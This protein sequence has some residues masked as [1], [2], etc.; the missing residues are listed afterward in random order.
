MR[1]ISRQVLGT[2]RE[3]NALHGLSWRSLQIIINSLKTNLWGIGLPSAPENSTLRRSKNRPHCKT[4]PAQASCCPKD[5]RQVKP[6]ALA[7]AGPHVRS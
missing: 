5:R 1:P 6:S 7:L 3:E 4:K 2:L